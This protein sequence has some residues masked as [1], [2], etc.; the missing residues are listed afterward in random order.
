MA[1]SMSYRNNHAAGVRVAAAA[2]KDSVRLTELGDHARLAKY[3]SRMAARA[4][5]SEAREQSF[6]H[7]YA[8]QRMD[9]T[10]FEHYFAAPTSH[11]PENEW[12]LI[13]IATD[14][15]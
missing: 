5:S 10:L 1:K 11:I 3:H 15:R 8:E 7:R 6:M 14:T 4:I 9:L 2:Y 13:A 12:V